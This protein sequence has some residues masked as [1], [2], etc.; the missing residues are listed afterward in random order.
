M[1]LPTIVV[2]R[3]CASVVSAGFLKL[4]DSPRYSGVAALP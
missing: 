2:R 3:P 1:R 4:G